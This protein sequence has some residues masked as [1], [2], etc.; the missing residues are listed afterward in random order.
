MQLQ[1]PNCNKI[2]PA[3]NINIQQMAAVCPHCDAVFRFDLSEPEKDQPMRRRKVKQPQRLQLND[4]EHHLHM[5]FRT[6]FNPAEDG[7]L[8]GAAALTAAF[9][10]LSVIMGA[11]WLEDGEFVLL[12]FTLVFMTTAILSGYAAA[13]IA[14]NKTYI[15]MDDAQLLITRGPIPERRPIELGLVGVKAF[16]YEETPASK[17]ESYDLPRYNVWAEMIDGAR[18]PLLSDLID[19]YAVFITQQ[20]NAR[21]PEEAEPNLARLSDETD[22]EIHHDDAPDATRD[23]QRA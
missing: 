14:Y 11:T 20:L 12:F 8:M 16:R 5:A 23:N 18:K 3:E 2:V 22:D 6:N 10:F 1:C 13:T 19:D 17:R 21:L 4:D 7:N 15:D 9:G